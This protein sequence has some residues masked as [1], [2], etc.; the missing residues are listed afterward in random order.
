MQPFDTFGSP[1][2]VKPSDYERKDHV[3]KLSY[4]AAQPSLATGTQNPSCVHSFF[5]PDRQTHLHEREGDGTRN[6]LLGW[7]DN[8]LSPESG[9][10]KKVNIQIHVLSPRF[11]SQHFFLSELIRIIFWPKSREIWWCLGLS[12][13]CSKF[14]KKFLLKKFFKKLLKKVINFLL[15]HCKIWN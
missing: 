1:V 8:R 3:T 11:R 6:I 7:P 12:T 9:K 10:R 14:Q 15:K 13:S 2:P 5:L 4:L